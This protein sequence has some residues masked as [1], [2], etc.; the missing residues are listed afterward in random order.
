MISYTADTV[1][2]IFWI[3]KM[4]KYKE[5]YNKGSIPLLSRYAITKENKNEI[6][7]AAIVPKLVLGTEIYKGSR[8]MRAIQYIFDENV[9]RVWNDEILYTDFNKNLS[10]ENNN[11]SW[12]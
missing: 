3:E 9:I 6:M 5:A 11:R 12:I 4:E 1:S 7:K 10:I 8:I 2:R